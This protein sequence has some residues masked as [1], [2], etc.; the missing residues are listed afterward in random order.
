M[1]LVSQRE[2]LDQMYE[3]AIVTGGDEF[4]FYIKMS[5][6]DLKEFYREEYENI[7][8]FNFAKE[9][10]SQLRQ[11]AQDLSEAGEVSEALQKINSL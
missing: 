7:K 1:E 5:R 9:I 11:L 2:E 4:E 10:L 6:G 8:A 3:S